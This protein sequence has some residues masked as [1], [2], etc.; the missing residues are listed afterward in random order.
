MLSAGKGTADIVAELACCHNPQE[1]CGWWSEK[2]GKVT[3]ECR[4]DMPGKGVSLL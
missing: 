3:D 4:S 1:S 2:K